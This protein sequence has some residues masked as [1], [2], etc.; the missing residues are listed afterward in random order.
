M[1]HEK[2]LGLQKRGRRTFAGVDAPQ[3]WGAFQLVR[4]H[5]V[6]I[7]G[8]GLHTTQGEILRWEEDRDEG[9]TVVM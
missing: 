9:A 4:F 5:F 3:F 6:H 1:A 8:G 2:D 7:G